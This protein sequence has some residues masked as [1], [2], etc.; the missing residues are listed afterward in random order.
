MEAPTPWVFAAAGLGSLIAFVVTLFQFGVPSSFLYF[1][2][3]SVAVVG[4]TAILI[5]G[6]SFK[7]LRSGD[8]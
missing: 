6:A 8:E 1:L 5:F 7:T 3:R 4:L 2:L